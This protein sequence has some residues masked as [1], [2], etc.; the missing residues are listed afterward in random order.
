MIP[1]PEE[2]PDLS[3]QAYSESHWKCA[4]RLA[5]GLVDQRDLDREWHL[6]RSSCVGR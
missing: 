2:K 6:A 5:F 3:V 1:G 4:T